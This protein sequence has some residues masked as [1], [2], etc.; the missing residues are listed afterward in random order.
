MKTII[1]LLLSIFLLLLLS[2]CYGNTE[3]KQDKTNPAADN[4]LSDKDIVE[5]YA[6]L[7]GRDLI[8]RQQRLDFEEGFEWNQLVHRKP[9][10]VEWPNPNLD[11]AYSEAWLALDENTC[12]LLEIPEVKGRYYTWHVLNA[13]GETLLNINERTFPNQPFGKYA[14][15]LKGGTPKIPDGY[16]RVDIPARISR[17]LARV[18]LGQ[19]EKEATRLQHLFKLTPQGKPQIAK[20]VKM[21]LFE[22][23]NVPGAELFDM[24][25]EMLANEPDNP[26]MDTIQAKA[27]E[28]EALLVNDPLSREKINGLI[29]KQ[30]V[31]EFVDLLHH[32]GPAKN[33]WA[34]PPVYGK[35]ENNYW[36]RDMVN[37]AGIWANT[38]EEVTYFANIGLDGGSTY[39][40]TF[41]KEALPE[42]KASYFWSVIAIDGTRYHVLPNPLKRYLLNKQSGVKYNTDGSLT[43]VFAP[44]EP[45]DHP[46][47][48]WL[49]TITGQKYNLTFRFYGPSAD[50]ISGNYYPPQLEKQ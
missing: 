14:L 1:K 15:C 41:P 18:E 4:A 25:T 29:T 46:Q 38:K 12:V 37:F 39:T 9:G 10:Q 23:L 28:V 31:Q 44:E 3:E 45:K 33:G 19:D 5:A 7:F 35:Y 32:P 30:F 21:P 40:M 17:V 42:S 47:Q 50:L 22:L 16:L 20:Q 6:Y 11:V 43:L 26:G 34:H 36:A 13:W 48:N 24:T 8:L 27:K 2:P 49:P